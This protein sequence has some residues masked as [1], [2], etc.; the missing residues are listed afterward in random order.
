LFSKSDVKRTNYRSTFLTKHPR[1]LVC[2]AAFT[3]RDKHGN[4]VN[5]YLYMIVIIADCDIGQYWCISIR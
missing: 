4:K 2:I 1:F 3:C 5:A